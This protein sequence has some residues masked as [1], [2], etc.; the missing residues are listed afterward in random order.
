MSCSVLMSVYYKESPIYFERA[1]ESIWSDQTVKPLQIVLV[2]DGPLKKDLEIII[3]DW[4]NKIG[5]K[6][7]IVSLS[8][9]VGLATALN[10]GL[11]YCKCDLVARMD[12]D[13]VCLPERLALQL[14]LFESQE[15]IDVVG[16]YAIEID[17]LEN[18]GRLRKMPVFHKE[19]VSSMW[20]CSLIHPTVM[21]KKNRIMSL[22]GYNASLR[23]R[24]DYDLW[25]RCVR[26]GLIFHNLPYPLILYR[27]DQSSHNKQSI[28]FALEQGIIGFKGTGMIQLTWWKRV[29]CFLPLFRSL[30]PSSL[31]H[32]LYFI[33]S[34]FDPRY[35]KNH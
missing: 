21:F 30:L 10:E 26:H 11:K 14:S 28:G 31:Q 7:E 5:N 20:A 1:I 18:R 33:L 24:Q 2:K 35:K 17:A 15:S 6:L 25:F 34:R 32:S 22:H 3:S 29:A 8:E 9:N 4:K 16:G 19:I 27:F 13:D 12:S 23:R